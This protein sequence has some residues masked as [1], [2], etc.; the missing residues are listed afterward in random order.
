MTY[1][2]PDESTMGSGVCFL[3]CSSISCIARP[4]SRGVILYLARSAT[5]TATPA[6][7]MG[8][9]DLVE[10]AWLQGLIKLAAAYVHGV[11]GNPAGI[12]RNRDAWIQAWTQAVL[13]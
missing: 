3:V 1:G 5:P 6:H 2:E 7:W 8:T 13:K 11:R 9:D 12:V 10:R 4:R